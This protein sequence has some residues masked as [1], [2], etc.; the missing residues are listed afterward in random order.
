MFKGRQLAIAT[1]HCKE[2]VM[3]LLLEKSLGVSCFVPEDLDTDA[4]G[5]FTGE[6]ER[7]DDP[8]TTLRAKCQLA[9]A[10]SGCDLAVASEGSFGPHPTLGFVLS[11]DELVLLLDAKNGLEILGR[12]LSTETNFGG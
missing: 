7:K 12:D 9:M 3:A 2:Q 4:L 11:G 6:V 5:T 8:I 10:A 1:R